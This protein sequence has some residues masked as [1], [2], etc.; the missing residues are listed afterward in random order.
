MTVELSSIEQALDYLEKLETGQNLD[1]PVF[2]EKLSTLCIRVEGARYHASI[3]GELARGLWHVQEAIYSAAAYALTGHED[4]RKLTT[5]QRLALDLV[6]EVEE[7]STAFKAALKELFGKIGEGF[8]NMDAQTKSRTIIVVA[9]VV[10]GGFCIGGSLDVSRDIRKDKIKAQQNIDIQKQMIRQMEVFMNAMAQSPIAQKFDQAI[11][12]G[13]RAI[14]RSAPD[15][16][17]IDIGHTHIDA[18]KIQELN[19]RAPRV[20][21]VPEVLD[22]DFRIYKVDM[23]EPGIAKYVLAASGTGEFVAMLNEANFSE[24]DLTRV[25]EAVQ[26]RESIRLEVLI[27]RSKG[28]VRSAQIMQVF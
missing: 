9:L 16:T 5:E 15:A 26:K 18:E 2:G 20:S 27:A 11:T 17:S 25:L 23:R 8:I 7:G 6:F 4:I 21:T 12:E 24:G 10:A 19:K 3:S 14:V 1:A 13:A 22:M 28:E